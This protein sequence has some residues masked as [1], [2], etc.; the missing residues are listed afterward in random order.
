VDASGERNPSPDWCL[1]LGRVR[2]NDDNGTGGAQCKDGVLTCYISEEDAS[3]VAAGMTVTVDGQD[4]EIS[5]ISGVAQELS[6]ETDSRLL[7]IGALSAGAWV[8]EAKA[9]TELSDG[10]YEAVITTESISPM[11]FIIN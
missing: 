10:V 3:V 7:H 5:E 6:E 1:H 2:T 4:Y 8:Y 9:D 11:S